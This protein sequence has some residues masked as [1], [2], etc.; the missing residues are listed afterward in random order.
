MSP[1][2]GHIHALIDDLTRALASRPGVELDARSG[3]PGALEFALH[4]AQQQWVRVQIPHMAAEVASGLAANRGLTAAEAREFGGAIE[5]GLQLL[6][7][8]MAA[9]REWLRG[10]RGYATA[11]AKETTREQR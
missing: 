5:R 9:G 7:S 3:G 11:A 2:V 4:R 1:D 10:L 8:D 6:D